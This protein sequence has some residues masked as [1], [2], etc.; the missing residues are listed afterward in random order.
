M[1]II[2][3]SLSNVNIKKSVKIQYLIIAN[4][5]SLT[6]R[7]ILSHDPPM[8]DEEGGLNKLQ[9]FNLKQFHKLKLSV[10]IETLRATL[11][12]SETIDALFSW[13]IFAIFDSTYSICT[14]QTDIQTEMQP[15]L[16]TLN[17]FCWTYPKKSTP[18]LKNGGFKKLSE[19]ICKSSLI[20]I[21]LIFICEGVKWESPSG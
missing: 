6:V 7:I 2:L 16:F 12:Q 19:L 10:M 1:L 17:L 8:C 5:A 9:C 20:C 13:W 3:T 11:V 15:H 21:P 4:I 14:A 18:D